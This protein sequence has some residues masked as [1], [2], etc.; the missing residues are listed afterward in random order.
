VKQ[1]KLSPFRGTGTAVLGLA[2]AAVA[3]LAMNSAAVAGPHD[4]DHADHFAHVAAV[5][6]LD[7]QQKAAARKLHEEA[8]VKAAPIMEQARLQHDEI[9]AMLESGTADPREL[10]ERMIAMYATHKKLKAVHEQTMARLGA[11]LSAEQRAKLEKLH[12]E[13]AGGPGE[14]GHCMGGFGDGD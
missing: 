6:G 10:G 5:L 9:E 13:H 14:H 11:Q 12:K 2:A 7:D 8:A 3:A 1:K 4:K